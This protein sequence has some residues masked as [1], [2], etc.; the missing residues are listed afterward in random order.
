V[1]KSVLKI[2]KKKKGKERIKKIKIIWREKVEEISKIK[3]IKSY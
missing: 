1:R 3:S 2:G